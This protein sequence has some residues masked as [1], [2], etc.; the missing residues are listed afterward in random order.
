MRLLVAGGTGHTGERLVRRLL[1]A[2]HAVRVL[3][4]RTA[5]DPVLAALLDAGAESAEGDCTRRWMLWEAL[6]G[7]DALVSCAHVRYAAACVQAC[8]TVGVARYIQMS[9]ARRHTR[10]PCPSSR[11][12]IA[13][14]EAI[15]ASP[16]IYTIVRPTM[17]FGGRRDQ[18]MTRLVEWFRRHRWFPVFGDGSNLVQPVFVEDLLDAMMVAISQPE[19]SARRDFDIAGPEALPYRRFIAETARACGVR[20]PVLVPVPLALALTAARLAPRW[21]TARGL[22]AEQVQRMAEDK[23]VSIEPARAALGFNPRPFAEAIRLKARG[24]AEVDGERVRGE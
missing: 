5:R 24:L 19:V 22:S 13:G 15:V 14:E 8:E 7:C 10:F 2:G 18:N 6:A 17:I 1:R 9:S 21:L 16:L 20:E 4:R 3:S 11:E 12:V 23:D